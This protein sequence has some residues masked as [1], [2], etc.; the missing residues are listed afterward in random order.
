MHNVNIR[1]ATSAVEGKLRLSREDRFA[2]F[3]P[4]RPYCSDNLDHG[5]RIRPLDAALNQ[6]YL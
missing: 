1:T 4:T 6:K 2:V 5:L 3:L